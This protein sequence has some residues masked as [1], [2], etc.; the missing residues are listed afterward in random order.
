MIKKPCYQTLLVLSILMTFPAFADRPAA[1]EEPYAP[2]AN[3][4]PKETIVDDSGRPAAETIPAPVP[5]PVVQQR[6]RGDVLNMQAKPMMVKTLDFPRRGMTQDKVQNELGRP[7]EII[8][9]IGKPPITRWV[10]ND[11]IVYF[12]YSSVVHVVAK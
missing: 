4:Q 1:M 3:N 6:Q 5:A 2:P 8:P 7:L 12:E 9:A 11:R 10:Y